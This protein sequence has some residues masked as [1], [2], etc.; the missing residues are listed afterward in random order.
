[1][2]EV[3]AALESLINVLFAVR[4]QDEYSSVVVKLSEEDRDDS[5]A[6]H[7]GIVTLH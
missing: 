1:M 6:S 3:D 4:G 5:I 2:A 7:A